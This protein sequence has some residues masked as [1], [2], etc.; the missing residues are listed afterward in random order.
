[1]PL[2]Q[3]NVASILDVLRISGCSYRLDGYVRDFNVCVE[4]DHMKLLFE[5]KPASGYYIYRQ[6]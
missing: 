6:V 2:L 5:K 3:H 1:V 4:P